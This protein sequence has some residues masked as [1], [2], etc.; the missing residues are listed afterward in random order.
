MQTYDQDKMRELLRDFYNLTHIKICIYDAAGNELCY[1]PEKLSPFCK[2]LRENRQMDERCRACDKNAFLTC[3]KTRR[4]YVYTCHAGL[5]ECFSPVLYDGAI[6]GFIVIGQIRA[7]GADKFKS[8]PE[9]GGTCELFSFGAGKDDIDADGTVNSDEE[10][11]GTDSCKTRAA[12]KGMNYAPAERKELEEKYRALPVSDMDKIQSAVRILDAC[13]GYEYLKAFVKSQYS[14]IDSK[15]ENFI[16]E[17]LSKDLSVAVLCRTF[18]LSRSEVYS[19]FREYFSAS[20]ADYVKE[21]RLGKACELLENSA[22]TVQKIAAEIGIPDYNY[23]SK[24]FRRRFGASPSEYRK[25]F[26]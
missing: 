19:I 25:K 11:D 14:G 1:Y 26:R 15:I 12:A 23:F 21:R 16:E 8:V 9:S 10:P 7:D 20:V 17:N 22:L 13:A 2:K 5:L 24:Q 4:Q 3:R 6:I 18:R